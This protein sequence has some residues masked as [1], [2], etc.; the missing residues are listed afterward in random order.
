MLCGTN[1]M[2][3]VFQLKQ[4][5]V[6]IKQDIPKFKIL[7]VIRKLC[8]LLIQS[9]THYTVKHIENISYPINSPDI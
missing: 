4:L 1:Y 5:E 2:V 8:S 7:T 6:T 9:L 3:F